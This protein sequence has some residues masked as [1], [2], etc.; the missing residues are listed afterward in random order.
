[1]DKNHSSTY[2]D[3]GPGMSPSLR[4]F[5]EDRDRRRKLDENLASIDPNSVLGR[6]VKIEREAELC[7]QDLAVI[8][9][10]ERKA[11][12]HER[13]A[14]KDPWAA[15]PVYRELALYPKKSEEKRREKDRWA[16]YRLL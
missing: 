3:R 2:V 1:M 15:Y 12:L 9:N 13:W 14:R 10:R 8:E 5:Y 7:A 6:M 11:E 4:R 16:S